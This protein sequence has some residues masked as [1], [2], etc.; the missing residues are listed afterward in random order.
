MGQTV[1]I[2]GQLLRSLLNAW[3]QGIRG[4][5]DHTGFEDQEVGFL[6]LPY[7][8]SI[9]DRVHHGVGM[10]QQ[11][12]QVQHNLWYLSIKVGDTVDDG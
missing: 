5:A 10:G 8:I 1:I 6:E 9:D 11:D 2:H 4:L 7:F 3:V 12:A